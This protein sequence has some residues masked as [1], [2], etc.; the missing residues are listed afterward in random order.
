MDKVY[1]AKRKAGSSEPN[2]FNWVVQE[3]LS[4]LSYGKNNHGR[5]DETI[6]KNV[7]HFVHS[8]QMLIFQGIGRF[9]SP[10]LRFL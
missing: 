5:Q 9:F 1:R 3:L 10:V 2:R 4:P 6:K 8:Y 7:G